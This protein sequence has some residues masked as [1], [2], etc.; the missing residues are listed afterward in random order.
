MK[1][2]GATKEAMGHGPLPW[3]WLPDEGQFIVDA[4]GNIVAEIP[5]QGCNPIDGEFLVTAVN[6]RE[7]LREALRRLVAAAGFSLAT[8]GMIRGRDQLKSAKEAADAV[9]NE[10][11]PGTSAGGG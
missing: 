10:T 8:P 6:E 7:R 4:K 3:Q 5:C 9:L 2:T 1:P 11:T